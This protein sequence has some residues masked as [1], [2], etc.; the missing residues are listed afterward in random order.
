MDCCRSMEAD[1][2]TVSTRCTYGHRPGQATAA[3]WYGVDSATDREDPAT[4][5]TTRYIHTDC[6]NPLTPTVAIWVQL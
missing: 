5:L 1:G 2:E 6:V 3:P 4:Q